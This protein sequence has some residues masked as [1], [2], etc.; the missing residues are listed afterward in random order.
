MASF[1]KRNGR[2]QAEISKNG[3]RQ[4]KSFDSKAEAKD[5][6]AVTEA[7]ITQNT[8]EKFESGPF[9]K[10]IDRYA[11]TVSI[12]KKSARWE[13]IRLEKMM[14]YPIADIPMK[15]LSPRHFAEWRDKRLE[16]VSGSS[17]NREMQTLSHAL[18][19]AVN[20][21]E[22]LPKN[23]MQGVRRPK[24]NKPRDR[25]ISQD[26][27]DLLIYVSGYKKDKPPQKVQELVIHTFLFALET[28]MRAG[29]ILGLEWKDVDLERRVATLQDTKNGDKREVPLSTEAIR[30]LKMLPDTV[31]GLKSSQLDSVFRKM[32][33][34][35]MIDDLHF[36]DTRHEAITRL[37]SKLDVLALARMVGHRNIAMLQVYYNESAEDLAKRLD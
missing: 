35:A 24:K 34:Q 33:K 12:H 15:D 25:R 7:E 26:E 14:R 3:K 22:W 21:W 19:T 37:A 36:H 28:A 30:L 4:A 16:E 1:R 17:V 11:R 13:I 23:P 5:W 27:I 18:N 20:E 8:A 10:L 9:R 29:E 6:A 31:F 32:R 2:W